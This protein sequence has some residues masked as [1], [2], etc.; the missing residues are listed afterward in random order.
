MIDGCPAGLLISEEEI[1]R[2][3]E[4]RRPG[5][6]PYT[7]PRKERDLAEI[8]SGV[9]EGKTTGAPISILIA[10]HDA[11]SS[12]YDEMK[13]TLRPSHASFTYRE[14]YGHFDHRGGGRASGRETAA[15]VAAGA[16]AKKFLMEFGIETAAYLKQIA[17]IEAMKPE[18]EEIDSLKEQTYKSSI[19]CPDQRAEAK[20]KQLIEE[21]KLSG[22]SLGGIIEFR[23]EGLIAGLGEPTYEKITARLSHAMLTIPACKGIEFGSGFSAAKMRGSE[24][25]D[26]FVKNI[27][28]HTITKTNHCGGTLGGISSG[29]PLILR[30][31]FKPTSSINLPQETLDSYGNLV[32]F[33]LPQGSRHDPCIAIRAVPV[34]EAMGALVLA[35]A[36]LMHRSS[37]VFDQ[38]ARAFSY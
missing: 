14:K 28:G 8:Y 4:L 15:R 19:F 27:E 1:N 6:N 33:N 11:D 2:D 24:H 34:V 12:K 29:M 17:D 22:D 32:E 16:I 18:H 3:L 5:N 38:S 31:A 30:C 21:T 23:A 36:I 25:N 7:S 10:N 9:Y 13:D 20:M 26:C 35:D 37:R